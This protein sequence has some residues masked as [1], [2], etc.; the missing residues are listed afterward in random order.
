MKT[1]VEMV[2]ISDKVLM[3][4]LADK[5]YMGCSN[6]SEAIAI[7]AGYYYATGKRGTAF[8]SADGFMN[9]L[10]FLTSWIIPD[11]IPMHLAISIGRQELPHFI[12][13]ETTRPIIELLTKYEGDITYEFICL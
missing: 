6:E 10:N 13:T 2:G 1:P 8:M 11:K 7:A 3:P 4:W 12:A 9:T 5:H